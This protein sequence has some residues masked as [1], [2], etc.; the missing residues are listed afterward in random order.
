MLRSRIL[1]A[2][3]IVA[4]V[5]PFT[6]GRV[7]AQS[8]AP[9]TQSFAFASSSSP[10]SPALTLGGRNA[11]TVFVSS[12][13]GFVLVPQA[14]TDGGVTWATDTGISSGS[15]T[16]TGA[17]AG[18]LNTVAPTNFRIA[19]T[20]D[21]GGSVVGTISCG[22]SA[23]AG[24][25]SGGTAGT[26]SVTNFPAVQSVQPAPSSTFNVQAA[27][28]G[29]VPVVLPTNAA[30]GGANVHLAN[31]PAPSATNA[32][33]G[34]LVHQQN[35]PTPIP[36]PAGGIYPVSGVPTPIPTPAGGIYPISGAPTPIATP[37]GGIYPVSGTVSATVTNLGSPAPYIPGAFNTS[38]TPAP[39]NLD[40]TGAL[41]TNSST[42]FGLANTAP[43][44]TRIV[45][46][47]AS[48]TATVFT[49]SDA[50][51]NAASL[52]TE[53]FGMGYNTTTNQWDR[54]R[55]AAGLG[56]GYTANVLAT[57]LCDP[58]LAICSRLDSLGNQNIN[59]AAITPQGGSGS[60]TSA[61]VGDVIPSSGYGSITFT[62][63]GTY[64]ASTYA[65]QA[66]SDGG[67]TYPWTLPMGNSSG[68]YV[69]SATTNNSFKANIAGYDH[70][71]VIFTT[72]GSGTLNVAW[73]L[74]VPPPA[75]LVAAYS[76]ASAVC[77][78]SATLTCA[79]VQTPNTA[80]SFQSSL[81]VAAAPII[82]NGATTDPARS[83]SAYAAPSTV[84]G[85]A[86]VGGVCNLSAPISSITAVTQLVALSS[87]KIP[88][89]CGYTLTATTTSGAAT[90]QFESG[91]GTTCGTGTAT[92]TGPMSITASTPLVA[93]SVGQL[94]NAPVSTALCLLPGG[95]GTSVSGYITYG[96][97]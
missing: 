70:V 57:A 65:L 50:V 84:V 29:T 47:S 19:I 16:T 23:S 20:S 27:I 8:I 51:S 89:V 93:N 5:A 73:N 49:P 30:D 80:Q 78:N 36:T 60:S 58:I 54:L 45:S 63:T 94:F 76:A 15:I 48:A 56:T 14:S 61:S 88:I 7:V 18:N 72:Y 74:A 4:L 53:S 42:G 3:A 97:Q 40:A 24:A 95:T 69:T 91:T 64:S 32:D 31:T 38:A 79:T 10:P 37:V 92:I 41:L 87:G 17:S 90:L 62:T 35:N 13:S 67:N 82:Y 66:S 22:V 33:G 96:L 28:T 39:L 26:T 68:A 11:C 55:E 12:G 81:Y 9:V 77:T 25:G 34:L 44:Y 86:A 1:A 75:P 85:V 52:L 2:L 21:T 71:R 46:G 43:A 6:A 59:V 83:T